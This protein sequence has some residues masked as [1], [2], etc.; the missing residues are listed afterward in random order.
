MELSSQYGGHLSAALQLL[1]ECQRAGEWVAWVGNSKAPPYP[2]DMAEA[3]L[4][5]GH[6]TLVF[7]EKSQQAATSAVK[8]LHSGAFALIILDLAAWSGPT[9]LNMA[10][11]SRMAALTR[12]HRSALVALT[13]KKPRDQSLGSLVALR[14]QVENARWGVYIDVLK[15]KRHGPGQKTWQEAAPPA[16]LHRHPRIPLSVDGGPTTG[17]GPAA[18]G[19]G[20]GRATHRPASGSERASPGVRPAP[21]HALWGSVVANPLPASALA[22]A[23]LNGADY[24]GD[25]REA[26]GLLAA[27]R[28]LFSQ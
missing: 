26:Q 23:S 21:R 4:D 15:D 16:G 5:L 22:I 24:S 14:A 27:D 6:F 7:A 19:A 10:L 17:L 12:R 3:G 13:R 11:Q 20:Q 28:S 2:P 1:L 8:L 9:A 18:N 25:G